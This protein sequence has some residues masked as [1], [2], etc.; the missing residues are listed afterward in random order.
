VRSEKK[1]K[2]E[3]VAEFG[4]HDFF[5][6]LSVLIMYTRKSVKKKHKRTAKVIQCFG[7][8]IHISNEAHVLSHLYCQNTRA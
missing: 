3:N 8:A 6:D 5:F 7:L 1:R 4:F 2:M